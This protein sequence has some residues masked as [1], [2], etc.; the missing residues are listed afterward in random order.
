MQSSWNTKGSRT[1]LFFIF[2]IDLPNGREKGD[3]IPSSSSIASLA[4]NL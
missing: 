2:D 4:A 1:G 3:S